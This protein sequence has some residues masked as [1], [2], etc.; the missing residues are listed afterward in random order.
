MDDD[1]DADPSVYDLAK[2][3]QVNLATPTT[4]YDP[5]RGRHRQLDG[6]DGTVYLVSYHVGNQHNREG[7]N[8]ATATASRPCA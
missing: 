1:P 2:D 6:T 4:T 8:C 3:E 5:R 7:I